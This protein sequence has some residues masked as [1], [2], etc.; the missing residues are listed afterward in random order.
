MQKLSLDFVGVPSVE[1]KRR[2][3]GP[4][5]AESILEPNNVGGKSSKGKSQMSCLF[6][7]SWDFSDL[8]NIDEKLY[9]AS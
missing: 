1:T 9:N 3:D 4:K 6:L 7:E 2:R 8:Y 5:D